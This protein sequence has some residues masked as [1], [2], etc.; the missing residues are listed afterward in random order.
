LL[1]G[2]W[3][4][5]ELTFAFRKPAPQSFRRVVR[6]SLEEWQHVSPW[7]FVEQK[8]PETA[9]VTFSMPAYWDRTLVLGSCTSWY[10]TATLVMIRAE[11]EVNR[12]AGKWHVGPPTYTPGYW[13]GNRWVQPRIDLA[14]VLLHEIGHVLR[15]RHD[16]EADDLMYWAISG[17]ISADDI[18]GVA[19]DAGGP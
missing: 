16:D 18:A 8:D 1:P 7:R 19:R 15:L 3:G 5:R 14:R 12:A 11:V 17:P 2:E 9:H 4:T 6:A 13:Q 10:Y